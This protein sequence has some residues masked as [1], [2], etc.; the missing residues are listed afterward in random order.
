MVNQRWGGLL[1]RH[2]GMRMAAAVI[3]LSAVLTFGVAE[4]AG[5]KPAAVLRAHE[6]RTV[7]TNEFGIP[8]P[9]AVA[10]ST[11]RGQLLVA[12]ERAAGTSVLRLGFDEDTHGAM[13]LPAIGAPGTLAVDE[14]GGRLTVV[15]GDRLLV[16]PGHGLGAD[17]PAVA[18]HPLPVALHDPVSAA[19][20]P[21]TGMWYVLDGG[22]L[23]TVTSGGVVTRRSLAGLESARL[24]GIAVNPVDGLL[25]VAGTGPDALFGLDGSGAVVSTYDLSDLGLM[26]PRGIAFAPSSD[27]TDDVEV[28]N[29]FV[30]DAGNAD[31]FGG[32]TEATLTPEVALAVPTITATL[33]RMTDT[34][35]WSPPSPDPSGVVYMPGRDRL[36]VTDSEV[37]ETTGAGYHGVNLWQTTRTGSVTDTGTAFGYPSR[38]PTG[39]GYDAGTDTLFVSDDNQ[40]RVYVVDPGSDGRFGTSDDGVGFVNAGAYGSTDTEDPEFLPTTGHLYFLDGIGT[41]VYDIDPVDGVFGNG[42]D[43]MRHFDVGKFGPTDWEGLSS[44]PSSGNLLVG[45]R[46]EKQI[47]E[48]TTTGSLIRVI[49]ASGIGGMRFISDLASGPATN[50]ASRTDFWIVD[51]AVDN[52]Q[53]P[54]ENDGKM[55]E[56]SIGG[57]TSNRPPVVTNPGSMSNTVGDSVSFQIQASDPDGDP[58]T[59][60]G[61]SGLPTGLSVNPSTGLISGTT[62]AAGTFTVTISATDSKGATGSALFAWSVSTS[63]SAL[64]FGPAADAF[65]RS[66]RPTKS[67]GSKPTIVVDAIPQKDGL[68]RFTVSGLSGAAANATLRLYCTDASPVGGTFYPVADGTWTELVTWNTAPPA[69]STAIAG[70]GAVSAGTSY[71]VDVSSYVT[72]NG[73]YS[74]R[75]VTSSKNAAAYASKEGG[76]ATAPTL[77]V[78]PA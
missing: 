68:L 2:S 52:G 7:W 43:V 76:A 53:N 12:A 23:V 25:Y 78:T 49:D 33:V 37:D 67:F 21:L 62:T 45:A 59:A 10:Y 16:V 15:D 20:D 38:E 32:I 71:D 72:G 26:D 1:L 69:G 3:S 77:V 4:R 39:L 74:I 70:L 56:I 60:Y 36:E 58:I 46:K 8:R 73:T 40:R 9:A 50:D 34:S 55:F 14:A 17:H 54:S 27:P 19:F 66:D 63:G 5:A 65:I 28:H 29:L 24:A 44:D 6:V 64:S 75:V 57:T 22:D 47:Y 61:A 13:R 41:E 35:K 31:S 11:S 42:N 18:A 30:A 48:V 51:R